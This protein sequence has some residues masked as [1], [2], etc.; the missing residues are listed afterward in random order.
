[1][2]KFSLVCAIIG[3][4]GGAFGVAID[5]GETVG[6][7]KD[8]IK[9][10]NANKLK[11]VNAKSLQLFLAK[12]DGRWLNWAEAEALTLDRDLQRF[13]EMDPTLVIQN[14]NYFG[15]KF[16]PGEGEVHV[17]VKVP[18]SPPNKRRKT[19]WQDQKTLDPNA[20][21]LSFDG[22][23]H[24]W[25]LNPADISGFGL[26]QF[27]STKLCLYCRDAAADLIAFLRDDV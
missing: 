5:A 22:R 12:K 21:A 19:L 20:S 11:D 8:A 17:L 7:L 24:V 16:Q 14:S 4:K 13:E 27:S 6:D 1:M 23:G 18:V 26:G 2:A 9:D 25:S 15:D 3:E 10:K